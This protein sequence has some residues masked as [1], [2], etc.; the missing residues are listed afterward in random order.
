MLVFARAS[1]GEGTEAA[2]AEGPMGGVLDRDE[3]P[4]PVPP[5]PPEGGVGLRAGALWSEEADAVARD[6]AVLACKSD[7]LLLGPLVRGPELG[8]LGGRP[9]RP[10]RI[11]KGGD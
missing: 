2:E 8:R 7:V 11:D 10:D 4:E 5:L 1:R 9:L 6:E 3:G